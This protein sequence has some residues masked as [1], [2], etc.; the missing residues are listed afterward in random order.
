MQSFSKL[1]GFLAGISFLVAHALCHPGEVHDATTVKND[2]DARGLMA[3]AA[4]RSLDACSTSIEARDLHTRSISRRANAVQK[5]RQERGIVGKA[6][7][8]R[9]DLDTL[10]KYDAMNH[11]MTGI[12]HYTLNTPE[13]D[14][15]S[16]N[17]SAILSPSITS[18]PYY[19]VGEQIRQNVVE[20]KWCDGI[21]LHLELQYIDVTTC[22]P[23]SGLWV[24]VWNSNATDLNASFDN[25]A[26]DGWNSTYLRGVQPSDED[27]VVK[28]DTIFPGHYYGRATHTHLLVHS[29]VTVNPNGTLEIGTGSVSHIGQLFY[30]TVLRDAAEATYPYDANTQPVTSNAEDAYAPGQADN[31]YDPFPEFLYLGNDITDGLF[32]WIQIGINTTANYANNGSIYNVAAV[33][34]AD[35]GHENLESPFFDGELVS[36]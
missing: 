34:E 32:A 9:R 26:A 22:E 7:K 6:Q 20:D 3:A 17:T 12:E 29:N 8:F 33:Y 35:G 1:T 28:F 21:P 23:V 13:H 36:T 14:I 31:D 30:N 2:I 5:L 11:N 24:D 25:K 4:R 16:A 15:F 10:E 18:G 19:V 27:G